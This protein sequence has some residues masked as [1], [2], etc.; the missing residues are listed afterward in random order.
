MY[1]IY[2]KYTWYIPVNRLSY[3]NVFYMTGIYQVYDICHIPVIYL[4]YTC[5]MK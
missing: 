4:V 1:S 2:L 5:H 3:A